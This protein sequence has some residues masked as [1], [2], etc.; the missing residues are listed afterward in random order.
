V[1]RL[2]LATV[3]ALAGLLPGP[4]ARAQNSGD[5]AAAEALF[6]EAQKLAQ[7]GKYAEACPKFA[8]SLRLDTGIGVMLYLADCY[9][10]TG[11]TA[12]AWAQFREAQELATRQSDRRAATA[13][14][15]ADALEPKLA[16]LVIRVE[17]GADLPR[18]EVKRDETLVLRPQWGVPVPVDPGMHTI[19]VS[20]PGKKPRQMP[21]QVIEGG[22]P[23]V[24][25]IPAL[26]DEAARGAEPQARSDA[27]PPGPGP[28]SGGGGRS[29]G[30]GQR[31]VAYTVGAAGLVGVGVGA[32]FGFDTISKN[33]SSNAGHCYPDNHCDKT[34]IQLRKSA[35][36]SATASNIAF[37]VGAA[38][39][40]GAVVLYFT[41]PSA[42]APT[43]GLA[44][45]ADARGGDLWL[46]ASW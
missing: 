45:S 32:Y 35:Q 27:A 24:L 15:Q 12:S 41:A 21:V 25:A 14:E 9:E 36:S 18:L 22:A 40:A 43:V 37:G 30:S 8:E 3:A 1:K 10:R 20:A 33:N 6:N 16:R 11:R 7:A 26:E 42:A 13:R 19:F 46:R 28:D 34:G 2:A 31:I 29:R 4:A 38:A 44:P 5:T 23:T 39:L 17:P